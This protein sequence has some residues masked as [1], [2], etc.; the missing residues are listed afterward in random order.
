[1]AKQTDFKGFS[2][3]LEK[4][5]ESIKPEE[6][7]QRAKG[8]YKETRERVEEVR[9]Q[10][11]MI[12]EKLRYATERTINAAAKKA[13]K[14]AAELGIWPEGTYE[15]IRWYVNNIEEKTKAPWYKRAVPAAYRE[16]I[17]NLLVIGR[18]IAET[19]KSPKERTKKI[20]KALY[21]AET[22]IESYRGVSEARKA[23]NRAY[24]K[25]A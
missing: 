20:I 15:V 3:V 13:A 12:L 14:V 10:V 17:E 7:K 19:K 4:L 11:Y 22:L 18:R 24:K 6:I 23:F 1:M 2:E 5:K 9:P 25:I 8:V 21:T 16:K